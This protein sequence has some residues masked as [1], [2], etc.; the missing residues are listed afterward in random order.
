MFGKHSE[1]IGSTGLA[2]AC[3]LGTPRAAAA[4]AGGGGAVVV[5]KCL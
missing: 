5:H 4:E 2:A 3:P 1:R